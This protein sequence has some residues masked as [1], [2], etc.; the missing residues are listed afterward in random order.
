VPIILICARRGLCRH[1]SVGMQ[2]GGY[3]AGLV[4]NVN[5][6]VMRMTRRAS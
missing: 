6:V 5:H 1:A 2:S 3:F 4:L